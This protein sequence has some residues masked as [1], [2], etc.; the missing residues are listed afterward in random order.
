MVFRRPPEQ[1]NLINSLRSRNCGQGERREKS[2]RLLSADID[3][4]AEFWSSA[5]RP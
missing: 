5:I 1:I 2:D 4:L 3:V